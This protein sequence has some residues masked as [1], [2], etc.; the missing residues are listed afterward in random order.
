MTEEAKWYRSPQGIAASAT[1]VAMLAGFWFSREKQMWEYG[2][3][4][5]ALETRGSNAITTAGGRLQ[6]LEE[7]IQSLKDQLMVMER[8]IDRIDFLQQEHDQKQ[9]QEHSGYAPYGQ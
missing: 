7:V 6:K 4:I 3:H 2:A 8:K 9:K 1:V 5:E